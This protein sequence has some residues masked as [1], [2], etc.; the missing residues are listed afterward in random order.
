M[1]MIKRETR[2]SLWFRL[3]SVIIVVLLAGTAILSAALAANARAMLERS[4]MTK[5]QGLAAFIAKLSQDPLVLKD[6]I[7]LDAI[8]NDANRDE[9][10]ITTV[11][12]DARGGLLT[13]RYASINVHSRRVKAVLA[14]LPKDS[15]LPTILAA[16]KR[17][18]AVREVTVP[19][20]I[21][22]RKLGSVTIGMS[23]YRIR[24][25]VIKTVLAVLALNTVV[26][27]VLGLALFALSKRILLTPISE[28]AQAAA[29]LAR[30]DASAQVTVEAAGELQTLVSSFNQMADDLQKTTVSRNYVDNIITSMRDGLMVSSPAGA[31]TRANAAACYL[32]GY[33]ETE[34]IGMPMDRFITDASNGGS[35]TLT[36][37]LQSSSLSGREKVCLARSGKQVPVLFSASVMRDGEGEILGIVCVARDITALKQTEAQL[38]SYSADLQEVNEELKSFAYIVSHDL[39]APLV[40]IRGFSEELGRSLEEIG[41]C[42]EKH[43][44]VLD[45]AER[46]KLGPLIR[47]DIPEALG[48]IRSSVTRMDSQI[49]SILKLSRAGRRKLVP[50][51]LHLEDLVRGILQTLAHQLESRTVAVTVGALPDLAADR[52][53]MEQIFGN[54]LDNAVKYLDP[55]RP[56]EIA[57]AAEEDER[58]VQFQVRDNGRGMAQDDIPKAFEIFRRVGKQDVPGEGMGLAYVKALVRSMGGRIWCESEPGSGTIFRFTVPKER[59]AA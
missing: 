10:V 12:R 36:E 7:G 29:R 25:E 16:I 20:A 48:F 42:F 52:T 44:P 8:V 1:S 43:L 56:G 18:E 32:L 6:S 55:G 58:E 50:E 59:P 4:L 40:N 15:D 51:P 26:A 46:K 54:L 33:D 23:N 5:A 11:I 45:E 2:E 24:R 49:G 14:E 30:G 17:E 27:V 57:V 19:V 39:R 3:L 9:D 13:S 35:S 41:P 31:I 28:L 22:G 34:L 37:I 53:A 21:D 38:K 47:Q